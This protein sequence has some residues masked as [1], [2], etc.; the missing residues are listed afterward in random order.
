MNTAT[1]LF[2]KLLLLAWTAVP[3]IAQFNSAIEGI[4]S[5]SSGAVI[6]DVEV[7]LSNID[8]GVSYK[9][10]TGSAGY[11]RFPSLQAGKYKITASKEGF[12]TVVQENIVLEAVRVQSV[13]LTMTVGAVKTEVNVSAAPPAVEMTEAHV[14]GLVSGVAIHDLPLAGRNILDV[15]AQT[16]GVTG[17]GTVGD[18]AGANDIF[19]L[20]NRPSVSANGQR[21]SSNGFY[22]DDTSVN[23][24]P[25]GGSAKLSPN[26][27]SVQE[28]RISVNNYSAQYGR[29]SSILTQIVT[30]SGNNDV[31]GSL[32]WF[33]QDNAITSRN[34]LQNTVDPLTNHIVPVSRRNEFG[35]SVGAPIRK[36]RTFVFGSW[37]QLRSAVATSSLITVE[38]PQFVDFMKTNFPNNV[39]TYLLSNFPATVSGL[40]PG[41]IETVADIAGS[42]TGTGPLGM[43]CNLPL[44]GQAVASL[45][46]PRNGLQWNVR[47][48]QIFANSKDRL[49][50]NVYRMTVEPTN[51]QSRP[52]F[53]YIRPGFTDYGGLNWTHTFSPTI[54]NEAALGFTRN[55]GF[56]P[57]AN[58]RVPGMFVVGLQGF[59]DFWGPGLF[60]QNDFHWRDLVAFNRGKHALKA[61]LDIYRD[62]DNAPFSGPVLRPFFGFLSIFDFANDAPFGEF[63][64]NFNPQTGGKPYED[65]EFRSTTYGFFVQ[66]DWKAKSNLSINLGLRW[67]FS[68]NPTEATGHLTNLQLGQGST[69]EERI[70]GAS[71][72]PVKA[73]FT[74]HRVGYFAPRFGFAWDPTN[75]GKMSIRGGLGV[76]FDRWPNKVWSDTTRGNPPYLAAISASIFDTSGP[77]PLF[78]LCGSD[79][80]PFNCPLP[81]FTVGLNPRNGPLSGLASIGGVDPGLKYAYSENWFLGAQYAFSQNWVLEGDYLGSAGHHLY[82]ARL[83]ARPAVVRRRG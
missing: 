53:G 35:G 52:A 77:Q 60:V 70:A 18:A 5:D 46:T 37:D 10:R 24:N 71:V 44:T 73:M 41:T 32:F 12:Q 79:Q 31:H 80:L 30:K 14:S 21:D 59:G 33:H 20:A 72:V 55:Q 51:T 11:Y 4:V 17:T 43:P 83:Q 50:G 74:D 57:C 54:V 68:S 61:G 6:P 1:R 42:C 15:I 19:N 65:Y 25:D 28:L 56:E 3:V 22:V 81:P 62:Q 23:D 82:T 64:I 2:F 45:S 48:D 63:N 40:R 67:D 16:P 75:K 78:K 47:V 8:T 29:N 9:A 69:F 76:F 26:V 34:Y 66:D 39:S 36:D 38:T 49:Y 27:D 13:P 58:C 7:S